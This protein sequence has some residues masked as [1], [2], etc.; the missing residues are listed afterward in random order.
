MLEIFLPGSGVGLGVFGESWVLL[1][2]SLQRVAGGEGVGVAPRAAVG[3]AAGDA[4]GTGFK[5]P[6]LLGRQLIQN[7]F[8][9]RMC[10]QLFKS[11]DIIVFSFAV[12]NGDF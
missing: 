3:N 6:C 12:P 7:E 5:Q 10:S 8:E 1:P 11:R 4:A 2:S 9:V